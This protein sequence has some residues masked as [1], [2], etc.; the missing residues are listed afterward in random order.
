[1]RD[2][3][4]DHNVHGSVQATA[5]ERYNRALGAWRAR[6]EACRYPYPSVYITF[7]CVVPTGTQVARLWQNE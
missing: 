6:D 1:M 7:S 3:H 2:L 4:L 5:H